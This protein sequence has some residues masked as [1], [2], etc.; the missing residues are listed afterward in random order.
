MQGEQ[1]NNDLQQKNSDLQNQVEEQNGQITKQNERIITLNKK[2]TKLINNM[3]KLNKRQDEPEIMRKLQNASNGDFGT[4]R[5]LDEGAYGSVFAGID[6]KKKRKFIECREA[7]GSDETKKCGNVYDEWHNKLNVKKKYIKESSAQN[8]IVAIKAINLTYARNVAK[9]V[10]EESD[11]MQSLH[12]D[13]IIL[14]HK[15]FKPNSFR[16]II[17]EYC[18]VGSMNTFFYDSNQSIDIPI[19]QNFARSMLSALRY[20]HENDIVHRDFKLE[21]VLVHETM[22]GY[23]FKLADFGGSYKLKD[24]YV[25]KKPEL[26]G[27][28]NAG[29]P[30]YYAP[31]IIPKSKKKNQDEE[32]E[33]AKV[34]I[35]ALGVAVYFLLTGRFTMGKF[36]HTVR[37]KS[38]LYY[39]SHHPLMIQP[40]AKVSFSFEDIKNMEDQQAFS[41]PIL[42]PDELLPEHIEEIN[43]MFE[44]RCNDGAKDFI[45][46][47]TLYSA[48]DRPTA[49]KLETHQWLS[50]TLVVNDVSEYVHRCLVEYAGITNTKKII[51]RNIKKTLSTDDI[52]AIRKILNKI[53]QI[54]PDAIVAEGSGPL[55]LTIVQLKELLISFGI[56]ASMDHSNKAISREDMGQYFIELDNNKVS[57]NIDSDGNVDLDHFIT[58]ILAPWFWKTNYKANLLF[59]EINGGADITFEKF[60]NSK[61]VNS[62][63]TPE[64][65]KLFTEIDGKKKSNDKISREEFRQWIVDVK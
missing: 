16:F 18:N 10:D 56:T 46:K 7:L 53:M 21:N 5:F 60:R 45:S 15:V 39:V 4:I 37:P 23:N 50:N 29:T 20:L 26:A 12:H 62:L 65:H 48:K 2:I 33:N 43:T 19:V 58:V 59:S 61:I 28:A 41:L 32:I 30:V 8:F 36:I 47:L 13:N 14:L 64:K 63:T 42:T 38:I 51:R 6:Y 49:E 11:L 1:K 27:G 17:M 34:D 35:Y 44:K 3:D 40:D 9:N 25:L 57:L 31:E 54:K 24:P 52:A 22:K 55:T